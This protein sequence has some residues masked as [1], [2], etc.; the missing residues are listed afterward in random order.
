M[1][2]AI[3]KLIEIIGGQGR[4]RTTD[5]AFSGPPTESPKWFEINGS[6]SGSRFTAARCSRIVRAR[7]HSVEITSSTLESVH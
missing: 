6:P 2:L 4:N 5:A 3:S 7:T 1:F